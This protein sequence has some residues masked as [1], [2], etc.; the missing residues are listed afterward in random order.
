LFL[1]FPLIL[2]IVV[3]GTIVECRGRL[4]SPHLFANEPVVRITHDGLTQLLHR[5]VLLVSRYQNQRQLQTRIGLGLR[6]RHGTSLGTI[7]LLPSRRDLSCRR[8]GFEFGAKVIVA[9]VD[10]PNGTDQTSLCV[11]DNRDGDVLQCI[12]LTDRIVLIC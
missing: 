5:F 10:Q 3:D 6:R 1:L 8:P 4:N 9:D 2:P 12:G 7:E 11:E